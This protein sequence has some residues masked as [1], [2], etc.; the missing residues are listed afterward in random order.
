MRAYFVGLGLAALLISV[1]CEQ[2][3][4]QARNTPT[5]SGLGSTMGGAV[6]GGSIAGAATAGGNFGQ[7][8][9]TF[10]R[11][12]P[13]GVVQLGHPNGGVLEAGA[14]PQVDGLAGGLGCA[15]LFQSPIAAGGQ[16]S[17]HGE[18]GQ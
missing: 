9:A 18:E 4:A 8:A 2:A 3:W 5:T 11:N 6:T 12:Q 10:N 16:G 17:G 13:A 7:A 1:H 15:G 14:E